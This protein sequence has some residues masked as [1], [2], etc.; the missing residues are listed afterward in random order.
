[1]SKTNLLGI[2]LNLL[3]ALDAL[4]NTQSVS[5]AA[6]QCCVTQSAMSL[7]LKQLRRIFNDQL[8][9]RGQA[10]R[11]LLSNKATSLIE[12]VKAALAQLNHVFS[13]ED[14]PLDFA[15]IKR[16]LN[17]GITTSIT[18]RLLNRI[19]DTIHQ[20]APGITVNFKTFQLATDTKAF[21]NRSVDLAITFNADAH[22]DLHCQLLYA[23]PLLCVAHH[24][25]PVFKHKAPISLATLAQYPQIL[26]SLRENHDQTL[27]ARWYEAHNTK[28][29]VLA[30]VPYIHQALELAARHHE[31]ISLCV[32][33]AIHQAHHPD[34]RSIPVDFPNK[35]H[36]LFWHDITHNDPVLKWV[37]SLI[38]EVCQHQV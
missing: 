2:N 10:S 8:L 26:W 9:I 12:P 18:S 17:I 4:L 31:A 34:L 7:S 21:L 15:N 35:E 28:R 5:L 3:M 22:L 6:E 19:F 1:M 38:C 37:R 29:D 36:A 27:T 24:A 14:Q 16:A 25:H 20:R 32:P 30:S 11:M 33:S 23:E 13:I